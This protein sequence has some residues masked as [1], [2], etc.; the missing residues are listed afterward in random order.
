MPFQFSIYEP[1]VACVFGGPCNV[2]NGAHD[3]HAYMT[4]LVCVRDSLA[5]KDETIFLVICIGG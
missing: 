2:H 3:W 5:H 4:C 1:L